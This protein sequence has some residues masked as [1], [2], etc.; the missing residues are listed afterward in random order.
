MDIWLFLFG[1]G[2]VSVTTFSIVLW[3]I[4]QKSNEAEAL[5]AENDL[6]RAEIEKYKKASKSFSAPR[7]ADWSGTVDGL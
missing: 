1:I 7:P 3:R 4:V 2:G 5:R 6:L